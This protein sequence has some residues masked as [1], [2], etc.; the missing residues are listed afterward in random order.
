MDGGGFVFVGDVF[1]GAEGD[2]AD[3]FSQG[4]GVESCGWDAGVETESP[5]DFI[6]HPVADSG[7][8]VLV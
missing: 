2:G 8:G 1:E 6:G 7:A 5:A 3:C 4:G